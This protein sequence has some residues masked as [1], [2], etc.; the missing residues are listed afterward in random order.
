MTLCQPCVVSRL[1]SRQLDSKP[2]CRSVMH[3]RTR[4]L[5][6]LDRR[7]VGRVAED[8]NGSDQ[9][10]D[11]MQ[12]LCTSAW[13]SG[14]THIIC[15]GKIRILPRF[16]PDGPTWP[17]GQD[18][19]DNSGPTWFFDSLFRCNVSRYRYCDPRDDTRTCPVDG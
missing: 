9:D 1:T 10:P 2:E 11:A 12:Q 4:R 19:P 16:L 6:E 3:R 8:S 13:Q 17:K 15:T 7:S 14:T 5:V 18:E